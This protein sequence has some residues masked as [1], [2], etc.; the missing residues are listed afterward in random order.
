MGGM[1]RR[2]GRACVRVDKRGKGGCE[3]DDRGSGQTGWVTANA[4]LFSRAGGG[5]GRDDG[6]R[7]RAR[8]RR[9]DT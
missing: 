1:G 2:V 3:F 9:R 7:A 6:G 8:G 5:R 4:L